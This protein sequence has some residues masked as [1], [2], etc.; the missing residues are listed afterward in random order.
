MPNTS[1]EEIISVWIKRIAI[2]AVVIIVASILFSA[3]VIVPAG[4]RGVL[5]EWSAVKGTL[6]E[7]MHFITPIRDRVEIMDVRT[8]KYE[9]NASAATKDLLDVA[10]TVAVNYHLN[11]EQT[12]ILYQTI[13]RDFQETLIAP[14]VQEVVKATTA[15]YNAGELIT[16]RPLVKT[17]IED[18]LRERMT[19]RNIIVETISIT[20]FEF[21]VAFNDAITAAQT[22]TK[23][24]EE[25]K[26]TLETIK[27][28]AEQKV[29]QARGE[30]D[31]KIA[32]A[33]AEAKALELQGEAIRKNPE[34]TQLRW[35]EKWDGHLPNY[36][37]GSNSLSVLQL[38]N[39]NE[40]QR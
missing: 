37:L 25:A 4:S 2:I 17:Q 38:P 27:F 15:N 11:P 28:E 39:F 10:T 22:A 20:N 19:D 13:G 35:I 16:E 3:I 40:T 29:A 21:P 14:A 6:T 23:Q 18:A 36:M 8:Q 34:I 7:G 24:A 26:N 33:T 31:A 32:T 1:D 9:T 5:L 30:A 12:A